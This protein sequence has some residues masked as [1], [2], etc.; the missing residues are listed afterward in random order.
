MCKVLDRVDDKE[1][2]CQQEMN[3]HVKF[4]G[5]EEHKIHTTLNGVLNMCVELFYKV[6]I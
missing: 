1:I 5:M 3:T 2:V 6:G 4:S